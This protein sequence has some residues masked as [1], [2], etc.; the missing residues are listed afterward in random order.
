MKTAKKLF[1][2]KHGRD[3]FKLGKYFVFADEIK[4]VGQLI[5]MFNPGD[6]YLGFSSYPAK[7]MSIGLNEITIEEA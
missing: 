1:S 4:D 2:V 3:I 5:K 7:V 6:G